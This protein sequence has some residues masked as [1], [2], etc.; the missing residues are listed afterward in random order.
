MKKI[1]V[2]IIAIFSLTLNAQQGIN[3]KA[4]VK[5]NLGNVVANQSIT[6]QFQILEGVG[7]TNVYQET[8]TPTTTT[9]GFVVLIMGTGTVNSG[10]FNTIDWGNDDHYLNVRINTGS[11]LIDMGTTQFSAVPYALHAKSV[12]GAVSKLNDLTDA[13][14][15]NDGTDN[16]S[17]VF[18]GIDAGL[19][20]DGTNNRNVGI[21]YQA[22]YSNTTGAVNTANGFHALYSNTTGSSNTAN[23][24]HALYSNTTGSSNTA[25]GYLALESN[26]EGNYNTANGYLALVKN[27]TGSFNTA[28]GD[29]ALFRNTTGY[30][31]TANGYRAL[32]SNTI[33]NSNTANGNEALYS[34]TTGTANTANG[35]KALDSNTTGHY[36]TAFGNTSLK[37]NVSGSYNVAIGNDALYNVTSGSNNIALGA[38]TTVPSATGSHQVRIGNSQITYAGVQV[39]W[40]VTSDKRWKDQIRE[41]P[42]GLNMVN[43]LQPVDY[44]RKNNTQQTREIGFIAQDVQKVLQDL[45]YNNQ[46]LLS[47]DDQGYLSIRYNDLIPVLTKAIQEQQEQIKKLQ[48]EKASYN[49]ELNNLQVKTEQQSKVLQQLLERVSIIENANSN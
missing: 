17:S 11:G 6:V 9:N 33:G 1:I 16:G 21:G 15:D 19:N 48:T 37:T 42:Y 38:A 45:G 46:G 30:Y 14:S 29:E 28:N 39:A 18:M 12:D 3:Y 24:F 8:H 31:N 43:R 20:D 34:N 13:K 4:L 27:T 25:N 10:V 32:Y 49:A 23:G 22:L 44:V 40:T 41:L 36:N 7:Q 5:D 35:N 2:F 47:K 26:T